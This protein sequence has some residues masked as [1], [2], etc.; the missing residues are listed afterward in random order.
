MMRFLLGWFLEQRSIVAGSAAVILFAI[1]LILRY[2]FGVWWPLGIVAATLL[3][4]AAM[5]IGSRE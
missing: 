1:T 2:G 4:I 5:F 3:G